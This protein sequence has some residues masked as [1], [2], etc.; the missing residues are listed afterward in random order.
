MKNVVWSILVALL[1]SLGMDA[2]AADRFSSVVVLSEAG[3][4]AADSAVPP[5]QFV[6]LLAGARSA[7]AA[8]LAAVLQD[9]TTHLLVLPYGS[10][11]PEASW[12]EIL[13]FLKGGGNLLVLGGRPFTRSAYHDVGGWHLRE[14][15]VRFARSLMIDQYQ[16]TPGF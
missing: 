2:L 10:A 13:T 1:L 16:T 12:P 5:S 11:F 3:F 15:S 6:E 7:S 8:Q 9:P 4:P 14:Y